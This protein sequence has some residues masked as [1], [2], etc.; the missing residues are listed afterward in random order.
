LGGRNDERGSDELLV[1]L[2]GFGVIICLIAVLRS[3]SKVPMQLQDLAFITLVIAPFVLIG[4][5]WLQLA[6]VWGRESVPRWRIWVS[7][8][9]C[10]AL[11][12]AVGI[13]FVGVFVFFSRFDWLR[14]M[15]WSLG[16]SA[17][18]VLTGIVGARPVRFPLF[19]GGAAIAG[20]ILI[21]PIGIL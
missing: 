20:L 7:S 15:P 21:I 10:I 13:P 11:L 6:R 12:V 18:A 1:A 5:S 4:L 2:G 3:G 14:A 16:L 19:L 17:V 8:V 9:G